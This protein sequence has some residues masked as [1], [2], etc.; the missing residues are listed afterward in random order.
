VAD[1]RPA[2]PDWP[3]AHGAP[4]LPAALRSC[5]EDFC[6]DEILGFDA[7]DD[8]EHDLLFVE[9]MSANTDW[10][11]RQ[12]ARHAGIRP[13][14]VG[15]SGLKDRHAVTR[16]YFSVRRPGRDGTDWSAFTADGVRLL[17]VRR[18]RRKLR[19]GSHAANRFRITARAAGLGDHGDIIAARWERIGLDGVPNY[20]GPQRFGRDGG[21]LSL[22]LELFAGRRLRR[23]QRSLA[24][25]AARAY[26]FNRIAAERVRAASWNRLLPG[27]IV[28]LAGS[29]SIFAAAEVTPDLATRCQDF[30]IHPTGS[31]WGEGAPR[32]VAAAADIELIAVAPAQAFADGLVASRLEVDS[33]PLRVRPESPVL[34][35]G[36]TS[37]VFEFVL[38]PGSYATSILRELFSDP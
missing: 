24:L 9:K 32:C 15:Y 25:S 31:L 6:V 27:D 17:S 21:N 26:L 37:T 14:D 19:R 20:F 3:R 28:N 22:A 30:D 7:S 1:Q 23:E 2:L 38:P 29:G 36:A 35:L 4:L 33:R 5:P 8:G 34:E 12:L 16:Q 10:V 11:A 18:H 13:A